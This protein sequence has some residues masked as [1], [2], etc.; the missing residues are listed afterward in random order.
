VPARPT[1]AALT[2]STYAKPGPVAR[3]DVVRGDGQVGAT[4][5]ALLT[6]VVF[7]FSDRYGNPTPRVAFQLYQLD[8]DGSQVGAALGEVSLTDTSRAIPWALTAQGGTQAMEVRVPPVALQGTT[9]VTATA[10]VPAA[11]KICYLNGFCLEPGESGLSWGEFHGIQVI[12]RVFDAAGR[13][14]PS[15]P[16]GCLPEVAMRQPPMSQA[17]YRYAVRTGAA[18]EGESNFGPRTHGPS[19]PDDAALFETL[20][21]SPTLP[22]LLRYSDQ[23]IDI[24]GGSAGVSSI[25]VCT[26]PPVTPQVF[27]TYPVTVSAEEPNLNCSWSIRVA[28]APTT[29]PSLKVG[30]AASLEFVP[31]D[32]GTIRNVQVSWT[33]QGATGPPYPAGVIEDFV[34]PTQVTVTGVDPGIMTLTFHIDYTKV[35]SRSFDQWFRS[36][37]FTPIPITVVP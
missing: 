35:G 33:I 16:I 24:R 13:S 19:A 31:N 9:R 18:I 11:I 29:Y 14:I 23:V 4:G 1:L 12:V 27:A 22:L 32:C 2:T 17:T 7:R 25:V 8:S 21:A 36:Q 5:A 28:A 3:A 34:N 26:A 37:D 30:E 6:P 15:V 20:P 10:L